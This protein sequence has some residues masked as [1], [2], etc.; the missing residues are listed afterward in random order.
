MRLRHLFAGLIGLFPV[1]VFATVVGPYPGIGPL[2]C[3][4]WTP[5]E[6][7]DRGNQTVPQVSGYVLNGTTY[8]SK[9]QFAAADCIGKNASTGRPYTIYQVGAEP[10]ER[11]E[12]YAC[13]CYRYCQGDTYPYGE[14]SGFY[15]D[16][17][18]YFPASSPSCP[19]GYSPISGSNPALC[20]KPNDCPN[21]YTGSAVSPSQCTLSVNWAKV[22][23]CPA[24]ECKAQ[25]YAGKGTVFM[26]DD[27]PNFCANNCELSGGKTVSF[28][29]PTTVGGVAGTSWEGDWYGVGNT[30]PVGVP[31]PDPNAI[32]LDANHPPKDATS[33]PPVDSTI[34]DTSC[35][36]DAY[37]NKLC[38]DRNQPGC[39]YVDGSRYCGDEFKEGDG[40]KVVGGANV[41]CWSKGGPIPSPPPVNNTEPSPSPIAK[42]KIPCW[43]DVP[44]G[45][46]G[47]N[48]TSGIVYN[49]PGPSGNGSDPDYDGG[50]GGGGS[51]GNCPGC[52][53]ESTQK[54]NK[55]LLTQIRD[56]L[57]KDNSSYKNLSDSKYFSESLDQFKGAIMGGPLGG[58]L[59]AGFSDGG[60]T[61]PVYTISI[62]FFNREFTLDGHCDLMQKIGPTL[63]AVMMG[64][65]TISGI[66]IVLGA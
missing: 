38:S 42:V 23:D 31:K 64:V 63:E 5:P 28:G 54:E 32:E 58:I 37:G 29:F 2:G 15:P 18:R 26:P 51:G 44:N 43:T 55:G 49:Y 17:R 7:V 53:Q 24:D 22:V 33:T 25:W 21:G 65:W 59:G 9:D 41:I 20:G 13:G 36:T 30:C 4:W 52:A 16:G 56:R 10:D 6:Y 1:L 35:V 62:A 50:G 61:C 66:L 48:D 14:N 39:G 57:G 27:N 8:T 40:C 12:W 46:N 45:C 3:P 19:E 34:P 60:G 11:G 47:G